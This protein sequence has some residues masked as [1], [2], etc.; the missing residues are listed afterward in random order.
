MF[1][2][3]LFLIKNLTTKKNQKKKKKPL[4]NCVIYT[5]TFQQVAA[6]TN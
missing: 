4:S 1:C 6:T 2:L 3:L 5:Y